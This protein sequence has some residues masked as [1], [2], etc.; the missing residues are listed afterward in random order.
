M[1][2]IVALQVPFG[3]LVDLFT[4]NRLARLPAVEKIV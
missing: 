1:A 2:A 4:R 3:Q